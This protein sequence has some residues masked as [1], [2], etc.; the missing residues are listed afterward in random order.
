MPSNPETTKPRDEQ[1]I[2]ITPHIRVLYGA[3]V[4]TGGE[5]WT[6]WA[7]WD[8]YEE[9]CSVYRSREQAVQFAQQHAAEYEN[10]ER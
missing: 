10:G 3:T 5:A 4:E 7:V 8:D 2:Q 6:G 1:R 9:V